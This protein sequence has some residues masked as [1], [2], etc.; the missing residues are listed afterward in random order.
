MI[1]ASFKHPAKAE[2]CPL[3]DINIPERENLNSV[4]AD[5]EPEGDNTSF[6]SGSLSYSEIP[7][8]ETSD[9]EDDN[10]YGEDE[11]E[12]IELYGERQDM[13]IQYE[14]D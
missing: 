10:I 1:T 14:E 13:K 3:F 12:V 5:E 4:I 2:D 11:D 7:D 9:E 8:Q 6:S